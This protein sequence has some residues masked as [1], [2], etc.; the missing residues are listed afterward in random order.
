MGVGGRGKGKGFIS[1]D[2]RHLQCSRLNESCLSRVV[3]CHWREIGFFRVQFS[4]RGS[5]GHLSRRV[6]VALEVL[7]T[8]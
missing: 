7:F 4:W 2:H 6:H 5:G 8:G 1:P 3:R